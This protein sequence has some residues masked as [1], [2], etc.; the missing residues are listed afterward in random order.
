VL[1]LTVRPLPPER[2][3]SVTDLFADSARVAGWPVLT[4]DP[5]RPDEIRV[6]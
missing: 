5:R 4:I 1:A 2:P 6:G 3:P